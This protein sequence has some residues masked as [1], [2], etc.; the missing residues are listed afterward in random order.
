VQRKE[1]D[2]NSH[3]VVASTTTIAIVEKGLETGV[4]DK[5]T[6]AQEVKVLQEEAA[7]PSA[8]VDEVEMV[9]S[10]ET[11]TRME[12]LQKASTVRVEGQTTE[13][14]RDVEIE[15]VVAVEEVVEGSLPEMVPLLLLQAKARA[16][17]S[18][19][20]LLPRLHQLQVLLLRPR[21]PPAHKATSKS[22]Y[23]LYTRYGEGYSCRSK[24]RHFGWNSGCSYGTE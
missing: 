13:A 18:L 16:Q 20:H 23:S 7:G 10:L 19:P 2:L 15:D 17:T 22:I 24:M 6:L 1:K 21:Q 4:T 14:I 11:T 3:V 12:V 8:V 9:S 5:A